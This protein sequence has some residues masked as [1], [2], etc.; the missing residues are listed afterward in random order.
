[1]CPWL[2][3]MLPASQTQSAETSGT[4]LDPAQTSG[5]Y[6]GSRVHLWWQPWIL[7]W[8]PRAPR[9][10]TLDPARATGGST[11]WILLVPD[12]SSAGTRYSFK[13]RQRHPVQS[14]GGH[15]WPQTFLGVARQDY[16]DREDSLMLHPFDLVP[17]QREHLFRWYNSSTDT[18]L[19]CRILLFT[20]IKFWQP[21]F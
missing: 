4:T 10:A 9:V 16:N 12:W 8:I 14:D 13:G 21:L 18:F 2:S 7:S 17:L 11:T 6:F 1:V 19:C 3:P 15:S 20:R 5:G